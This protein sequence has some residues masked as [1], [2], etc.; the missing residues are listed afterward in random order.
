MCAVWGGVLSARAWGAGTCTGQPLETPADCK[1][2]AKRARPMLAPEL[3]LCSYP[4]PPGPT[5]VGPSCSDW[6]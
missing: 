2:V 6:V 4:L 5:V 1:I 3:C